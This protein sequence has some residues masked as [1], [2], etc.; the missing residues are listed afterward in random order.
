[1]NRLRAPHA[2]FY[3]FHLCHPDTLTRLLTRFATVHFRDF[4]AL[5]LTPMSGM[6]AFQD[7][8]GMSFP[9]L[10][11]SGRLVQGY[12]VSGPLPSP[13]AAA[14]DRDL[15]DPLWRKRFHTALCQ[16]RRLQRGLFEPS[17]SLR[18]GDCLVPGPAALL[19]I[20]DDSFRRHVYD[21]DQ[22]RALSK[23]NLTLE[24]GYHY[25][26]GLALLK[27]S[28]SLVYTQTLALAHQLQ[29]VTDSPAHFS[30]YT[31]SSAREGWPSTNYLLIRVGY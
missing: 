12:A 23:R 8:M 14:I 10:I 7:R 19:R 11:E 2:L 21:L 9:G 26:Y 5:Q 27:T 17:H 22:V 3:P 1:M 25:E 31:Q 18:I 24:E 13:V 4:M 16:D 20:M 15:C 28:A 30:L 6:T 29:P